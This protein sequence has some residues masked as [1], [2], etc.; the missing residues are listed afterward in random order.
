MEPL[1]G[2]PR[3]RRISKA[4]RQGAGWGGEEKTWIVNITGKGWKMGYNMV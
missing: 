4:S 3:Q 2:I 1:I